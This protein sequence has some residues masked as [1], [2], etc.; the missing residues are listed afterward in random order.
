M[1]DQK[2]LILSDLKENTA[3]IISSA[4]SLSRIIGGK[5]VLFHVIKP[6][7]VV[8]RESQLS[9]LRKINEESLK[10]N[11]KIKSLI[12]G[13]NKKHNVSIEYAFSF[14]NVK[15]EIE[16]HIKSI[17][18]DVIVIGK[19]KAKFLNF[20]GKNLTEFVLSKHKGIVMLTPNSNTLQENKELFVAGINNSV[21]NF[22][23]Y[24]NPT[25]KS[26]DAIKTVKT[27]NIDCNLDDR[28]N[29]VKDLSEYVLKNN[30]DLLC[31]SNDVKNIANKG[32]VNSSIKKIINNTNVPVLLGH[33]N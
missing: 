32:K 12:E 16:S 3:N 22:N 21:K 31:L 28:K 23:A 26:S 10:I 24:L 33:E 6:I 9:A 13:V 14:G 8:N 29:T 17:N 25:E 20:I 19:R 18:P 11:N 4:I 2:I 7:D 27:A 5:I 15:N 1:E 30:V